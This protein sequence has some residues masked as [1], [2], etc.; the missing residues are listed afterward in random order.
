MVM[1]SKMIAVG[2]SK[3]V[4]SKAGLQKHTIPALQL[5]PVCLDPGEA[6]GAVTGPM[7]A[8]MCLRDHYV[9]GGLPPL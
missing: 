7:F 5:S 1:A 2:L 9:T 4:L 6:S 8:N 3:E